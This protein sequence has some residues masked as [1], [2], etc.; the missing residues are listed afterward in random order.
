MRVFITG[1][2]GYIGY[3]V[4]SELSRN[5]HEVYG[6][7][8]TESKAK[9]LSAAEVLPV[10]GDMQTPGSYT[11]AARS[12]DV[13]IHSAAEYSPQYMELDRA[14]VRTL[15][16]IGRASN[17]PK[18][19]IYT[20]GCWLLGNTGPLP[21]N[22]S[23]PLKPPAMVAP[24]RDTEKMVEAADDGRL[25]TL[26]L[27][28]A[29]VYGG[30]GGLTATWFESAER[31]GAPHILGDGTYHWTMVHV[32][33]LALAYRRAAES[34]LR[35]EVLNINDRSHASVLECAQAVGRVVKGAD[36]VIT[37]PIEEAT[38]KMGPVV[39][40]LTLDQHVDASRA[41]RLLGWNPLHTGFV[42]GVR[43]YYE[44]WKASR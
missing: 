42:D 23:S 6:L 34:D 31:E 41:S 43:R 29:C 18:L 19:F 37:T 15:I 11:E 4:A 22:E 35:G 17:E 13:L 3:A 33:D 44:S 2:T 16:E 32:A 30:S 28:P 36:R 10:M 39:E 40:C 1:A 20:S 14:T 24:R 7:A 5:A 21:A 12:A 38:Q 27:R 25:R 9:Q 8:R 26:I